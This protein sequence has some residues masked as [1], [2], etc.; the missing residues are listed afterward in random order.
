[1]P[2]TES[3]DIRV[4]VKTL[5]GNTHSLELKR[6]AY[7]FQLAGMLYEIEGIPPAQQRLIFAGK[8]LPLDDGEDEVAN[9]KLY[10]VIVD[11]RQAL[12]VRLTDSAGRRYRW[13]RNHARV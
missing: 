11:L 3:E 4:T 1:M 7:M 9:I 6:N 5:T 8:T 12:S 2:G 10:Q 13:V